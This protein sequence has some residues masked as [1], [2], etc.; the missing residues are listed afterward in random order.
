ML[1]TEP[2][3][4]KNIP[5]RNFYWHFYEKVKNQEIDRQKFFEN[6]GVGISVVNQMQFFSGL[7]NGH[8]GITVD[9]IQ[10]AWDHYQLSPNFLF[11]IL[12]EALAAEPDPLYAK[13][14]ST[15]ISKIRKLLDEVEKKIKSR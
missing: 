15:D 12:A 6:M 9:H 10:A 4:F 11:G 3:S 1:R 13:S 2:D 8:K 5:S 7:R 14:I